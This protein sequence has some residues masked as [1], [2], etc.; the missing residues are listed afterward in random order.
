MKNILLITD[1]YPPEV[2]SASLMM[3]E[4]ARGLS[5][6]GHKVSVITSMPKYNLIEGQLPSKELYSRKSEDGIQ[7]YRVRTL[8]L[9][10]VSHIKR[11]LGQMVLPAIFSLVSSF[12][13]GIDLSIVYS[14]PLPLGLAAYYLKIFKGAEFIFN[15][16]DLFP[17][18]AIDLGALK[19]PGL[20]KVFQL[21]EK[22]IYRRA[23]YITVHSPGNKD[24]IA[25]IG[26]ASEKISIIH[27]WVDP[28]VYEGVSGRSPLDEGVDLHGKFVVLF[29]GVMSYAQDMDVIVDAARL[30][31]EY[32]NIVFLL[33][34]DGSQGSKVA[35]LKE[36]YGLSNLILHPF[37]SLEKYP[38]LVGLCDVGLVT[39]KKSMKTP[40]VPSKILGYMAAGRPIIGS[41]NIESEANDIIKASGCG[42]SEEINCPRDMADAIVKLYRNPELKERMGRMG[43]E[44]VSANYSMEKSLL[45]YEDLLARTAK[46]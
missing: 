4:L 39:L 32:K 2:R 30:L 22:F 7:V 20:I 38:E 29:A 5:R 9:H 26:I 1:S 31:S 33:V 10:N 21:L 3:Y 46:V 25:G 36:K 27:N 8:P 42:W 16:Q 43:R 24:F 11:G 40:V 28:T 12:I 34:G 19:N 41:L 35:G 13:G 14:P 44:Y 23:R 45:A 17:Q 15:V 6:S 18:N 37:V